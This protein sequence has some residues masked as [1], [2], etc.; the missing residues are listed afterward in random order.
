[1]K[2][3]SGE[4]SEFLSFSVSRSCWHLSA[5][6]VINKMPSWQDLWRGEREIVDLKPIPLESVES[7]R[8]YRRPA[9]IMFALSSN[10]HSL[11]LVAVVASG[12]SL[13]LLCS[14][15]SENRTWQLMES[16]SL[17]PLLLLQLH[18]RAPK[19]IP[20]LNLGGDD[21][22]KNQTFIPRFRA[23]GLWERGH[24]PLGLYMYTH[25]QSGLCYC[26]MEQRLLLRLFLESN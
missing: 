18:T 2:S 26:R 6:G 21:E 9:S 1:M 8:C 23:G 17:D 7:V 5:P 3:R 10:T 24:V 19:G 14:V 4:E 11:E 16:L 20:K 25:T 22:T 13:A 15:P 12:L